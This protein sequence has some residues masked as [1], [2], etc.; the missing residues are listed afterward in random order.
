MISLNNMNQFFNSKVFTNLACDLT[1][2]FQSFIS[3]TQI[4]SRSLENLRFLIFKV[5]FLGQKISLILPKVI[6]SEE[7]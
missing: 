4:L 5:N 3:L 1:W 7:Y 6:F 2:P